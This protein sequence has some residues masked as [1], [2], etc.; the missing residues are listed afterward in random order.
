MRKV[1]RLSYKTH[2]LH[3]EAAWQRLEPHLAPLDESTV[4]RPAAA[5]RVLARDLLATTDVPATDVSAMDGYAVDAGVEAGTALRVTATIA[6]GSPPGLY[7][8]PGTAARIMTGAPVPEGADRVIP[9]ESSERGLGEGTAGTEG[10]ERVRFRELGEPGAHIRRRG[11]ITARGAPLLRRGTLITHGAVALLASHGIASVPVVRRPRLA[12]LTTG[13]EV[14]PADREPGPG[15]LRDSHSD[16]FSSVGSRL[17]ESVEL[18]GIVPDRKEEL[19]AGVERGLRADVLILTGGVSMGEFDLVEGALAGRG[20]EVLFD[21]VAIQPGKPVV[22]A[23]HPGGLVFALPGN[24]ASAMVTFWL[25]VRP[26]LRRLQGLEDRYWGGALL[27]E[28]EAPLPSARGRDL[29]LPARVRFVDGTPRVT[30]VLPQGSHDV[31]AYAHGTA[32][33]RVKVGDPERRA[34]EACEILPLIEWPVDTPSASR[35][36]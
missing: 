5:G 29:F 28:L 33:V 12:M 3:P 15:Q 20:C 19:A 27:G 34:G 35:G 23:R 24:P 25:F 21:A 16:F 9:V 11:E 22:A 10:A 1:H 31:A 17:G 30:P 8:E 32:L 6:A 18:L 26:A 4:P 36:A 2:M 13:D 7:L 14:V